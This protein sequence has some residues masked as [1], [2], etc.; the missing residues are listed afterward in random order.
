MPWDFEG[1]VY[2][3]VAVDAFYHALFFPGRPWVFSFKPA[4]F[5]PVRYVRIEPEELH[6]LSW[7]PT[8]IRAFYNRIIRDTRRAKES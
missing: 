7:D 1:E 2:R 6:Q 5:E 8:P 4:P 3:E